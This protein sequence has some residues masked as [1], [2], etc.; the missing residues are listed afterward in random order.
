MAARQLWERDQQL[1]TASAR[2]AAARQ[3]SGGALFLL[4]EAGLG[5]SSLLDEIC[6]QAG[7]LRIA[8][9]RGDPMEASLA[10]GF[11]S[12]VVHDLG[13]EEERWTVMGGQ[14]GGRAAALYGALR[15][16]E[17]VAREPVLIALDDLQWADPDSLAVVGFLC[18]RLGGLPV[19]VVASLRP[20]PVEAAELAW[21]LARRGDAVVERLLPLS[22]QAATEMLAGRAG[23]PCPPDTARRAW[24]LSGG[25]P[26]LLGLVVG[27]VGPE[28]GGPG[29]A[30]EVPLSVAERSLVLARFAGLG[31][32]GTRWA[33]A[34]AALGIDFSPELASEV[35]G[36]EG[37]AA[38]V[39]ADALWRNGLVRTSGNRGAEFIHPLF[40]QLLYEDMSP[41]LRA[42][43]HARAFNALTARRMDEVAAEHAVRA[44]LAGDADAIRVLTDTGRRA[45]RAG[46]VATG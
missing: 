17:E 41:L 21:S 38:E 3:G 13:G 39:A 31:S 12:Q 14:A 37:E 30:E 10:F 40:Q 15:W 46:A 18:R 29:E 26:L 45:L 1:R 6:R 9:A 24:R 2:V 4:A 23:A 36:L 8:R 32:E 5:K 42:H 19:A 35:A 16:L 43:L 20:W 27:G 11:L 7:D 25:N 33:Q 34:A 44:N 22:E 28:G